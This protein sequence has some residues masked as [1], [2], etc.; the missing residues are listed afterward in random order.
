M[1]AVS[2]S[3]PAAGMHLVELSDRQGYA[4]TLR[5]DSNLEAINWRICLMV[6]QLQ[7][8]YSQHGTLLG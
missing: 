1:L 8:N 3:M 2:H 7:M 5:G 6:Q 4:I